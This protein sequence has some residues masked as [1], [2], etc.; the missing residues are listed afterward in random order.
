[1]E[2]VKIF[3]ECNN[4]GGLEK[5][6]NEFLKTIDDPNDITKYIQTQSGSSDYHVVVS[7]FYIGKE[8]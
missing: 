2:K 7:I 3:Y 8:D 6:V 1:M 5:R 4:V